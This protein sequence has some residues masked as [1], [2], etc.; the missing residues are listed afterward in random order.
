VDAI[1]L[2]K[3]IAANIWEPVYEPYENSGT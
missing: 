1:G 2:E 3:E